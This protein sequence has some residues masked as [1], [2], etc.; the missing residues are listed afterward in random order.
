MAKSIVPTQLGAPPPVNYYDLLN[1]LIDIK[2]AMR[3]ARDGLEKA[4]DNFVGNVD[5]D[6]IVDPKEL[7]SAAHSVL[8]MAMQTLSS[9]TR[10]SG[11]LGRSPTRRWPMAEDLHYTLTVAIPAE[12]DAILHNVA[13][14][15]GQDKSEVI[16]ELLEQW[17]AKKATEYQMAKQ[18]R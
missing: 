13:R 3:L 8:G 2:G 4:G 9:I 15:F 5:R 1:E 6:E 17:A 7:I 18:L 11:S 12:T 14:A 10:R 16:R